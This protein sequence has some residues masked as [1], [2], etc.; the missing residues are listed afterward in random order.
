LNEN[1]EEKIDLMKYLDRFYRAFSKLKKWI[2]VILI[3]CTAAIEARTFFF[4]NTTYSSNAVF[5]VSKAEQ[6]NI[7]VSSDDNDDFLSTFN[8]L[9]TGDMMKKVIMKDL[10]VSVI[11]G[12]ISLSR[13]PETN[14]I[15]L[16]VTSANAEDAYNV[17]N[18]MINNYSQVTDMV[19][20]DVTLSIL[21][22]PSLAEAP[23]ASPDYIRTGLKGLGIGLAISFVIIILYSIFRHTILNKDDVKKILHLS[24]LS[25]IPYIPGIKNN[26]AKSTSLLLSNPRIQYTFKSAFHDLRMKI[27]QENKKNGTK[28]IMVSSAMPHEGKSMTSANIAISLAQ[29]GHKVVLVDLDLRNRSILSSMNG[30]GFTGTVVD[31]LSG[32]LSFEEVKS[33]YEDYPMDIIFGVDSYTDAPE[34][35]SKNNFAKFIKVLRSKYDFVILDVPPV[36]M[37]ED[38]LLIANQCDSAVF[39]IKQDYVNAYDVL[40][41][42]EELNEHIPSIMGTVLNQVKPSFFDE[43]QTSRYGYGSKYGYGYGYGYGREGN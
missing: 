31:Y 41:A 26:S 37:M 19:M 20:S 33:R 40:D 22:T 13:I 11:P 17:I 21:D 24:N 34:L 27:E 8:N 29:K 5:I 14:L 2:L 42:L 1:T 9:M 10:G 15:E 25:S 36:Y 30:T 16:K 7:Y 38:A 32:K 12:R 35:L 6:S 28:V 4:F 43:E 23:D 39:V 3:I 18:C